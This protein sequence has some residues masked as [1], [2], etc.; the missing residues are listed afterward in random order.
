MSKLS[1]LKNN[2]LNVTAEVP[3]A[4]PLKAMGLKTQKTLRLCKAASNVIFSLHECLAQCSF[5]PLTA[6]SSSCLQGTA[7]TLTCL[8]LTLTLDFGAIG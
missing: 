6:P 4:N 7:L 2:V 1:V 5:E 8:T 3:W